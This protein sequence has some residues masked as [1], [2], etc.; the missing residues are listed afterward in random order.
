MKFRCVLFTL[1]L[2]VATSAYAGEYFLEVEQ[3]CSTTGDKIAF[4][5]KSKREQADFPD[6]GFLRPFA[7]ATEVE[8]RQHL[9][10]Q[11]AHEISPFV[12]CVVG[13]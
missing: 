3:S 12:R 9:L 7:F 11:W 2:L 13:V 1:A 8:G 10:T 4:E 6:I 5:C